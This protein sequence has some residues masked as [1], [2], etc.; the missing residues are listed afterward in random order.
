MHIEGESS[1]KCL[2]KGTILSRAGKYTFMQAP[3][4]AQTQTQTAIHTYTHK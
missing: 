4:N 2:A 3:T 1:V